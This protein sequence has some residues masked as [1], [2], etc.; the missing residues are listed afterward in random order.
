MS[1]KTNSMPRLTVI[2]LISGLLS[3][4]A[5][6]CLFWFV[7]PTA[8]LFLIVPAFMGFCLTAFGKVPAEEILDDEA[9]EKLSKRTGMLCAAM[10]LL[11]LANSLVPMLIILN[12]IYLLAN[13][14]FYIICALCAFIGYNRGVQVITDNYYDATT[15]A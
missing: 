15:E 13:F 12:P 5:A 6:N 9:V 2:C 10:V 3:G 1:T 4:L 14:G 7:Y 8:F 11:A